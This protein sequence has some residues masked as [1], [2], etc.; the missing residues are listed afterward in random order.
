M[1]LNL[2]PHPVYAGWGFFFFILDSEE[3][4]LGR[5]DLFFLKQR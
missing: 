1:W 5:R 2:D 4:Q 3:Q